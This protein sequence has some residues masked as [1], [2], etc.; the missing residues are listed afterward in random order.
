[1]LQPQNGLVA[2]K[3]KGLRIC[4]V[5]LCGNSSSAT[6]LGSEISLR[7]ASGQA[8]ARH[9]KVLWSACLLVLHHFLSIVWSGRPCVWK[10]LGKSLLVPSLKLRTD[11]QMQPQLRK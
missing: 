2:T 4:V 7:W 10:A 9:R 8:A 3:T 11:P 5:I 1:M 6:V